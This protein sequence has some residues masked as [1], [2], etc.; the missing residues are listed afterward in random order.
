ML[1]RP[2][3]T[4]TGLLSP[5]KSKCTR[6]K[7]A[8]SRLQGGA[9]VQIW[10]V[11]G[12]AESSGTEGHRRL[13]ALLALPRLARPLARPQHIVTAT[14]KQ[15]GET[16]E[17]AA[18]TT[19]PGGGGYGR[20]W[21]RQSVRPAPEGELSGGM[22][23]AC[24]PTQTTADSLKDSCRHLQLCLLGTPRLASGRV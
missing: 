7:C 12:R 4:E 15:G 23:P 20:G 8:A 2:E 6:L 17:A 3:L 21:A 13:A 24:C 19:K 16:N 5:P 11:G 14:R 1:R 22:G 9:R 10:V 18:K